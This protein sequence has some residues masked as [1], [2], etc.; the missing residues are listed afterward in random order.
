MVNF[1]SASVEV[2]T[3]TVSPAC[4]LTEAPGNGT[5]PLRTCPSTRQRGAAVGVDESC[6]ARAKG[7][8]DG[9]VSAAA[10]TPTTVQQQMASVPARPRSPTFIALP[11]LPQDPVRGF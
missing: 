11:R 2:A 9:A 8:A 3:L 4:T 6:G 1:P 5:F 7:A 10:P